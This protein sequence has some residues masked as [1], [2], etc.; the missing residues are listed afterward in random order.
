MKLH[1]PL[2]CFM[3]DMYWPLNCDKCGYTAEFPGEALLTLLG[4]ATDERLT[5][6]LIGAQYMRRTAEDE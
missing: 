2:T 5:R 4:W 6:A 1:E 3:F